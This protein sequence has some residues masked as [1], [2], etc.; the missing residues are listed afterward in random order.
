ML[1]SMDAVDLEDMALDP[2]VSANAILPPMPV[3]SAMPRET[4]V[5]T[6]VSDNEFVDELFNAFHEESS[7]GQEIFAMESPILPP[8]QTKVR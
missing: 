7:P 5:E 1:S 6:V 8:H 3:P 2:V 4:S